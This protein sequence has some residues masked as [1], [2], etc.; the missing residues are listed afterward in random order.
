M[1]TTY[2]HDIFGKEVYKR[3]PREIKAVV[4]EEKR[5]YLIGLHGPDILFYYHPFF[6]NK[7]SKTGYDLHEK[8][9][10][11]FFCRNIVR[12]QEE[13]S[14]GL[15]AY[16][17]GFTCHFILDS[18]CHPYVSEY[19]KKNGV[20]HA[21]IETELDRYY[22]LR[23]GKDPLRYRPGVS[24]SPSL[25][26]NRIIAGTF[27]GISEKQIAAA[28]K[29]MKFYTDIMVCKTKRKREFLLGL[30]KLAGC[31]DSM[32]GQFMREEPDARC[33]ISTDILRH[34]YEDALDEAVEAIKNVYRCMTEEERLSNRFNRNFE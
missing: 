13:P 18:C 30:L 3:L 6:K 31:Y 24:I 33:E 9:A 22:M 5:L 27:L 1:P 23:E 16:L 11:E 19:E 32:E 12:Y 14:K 15:M 29:G 20:S 2:T 34:L 28:L 7:V 26:S 21:G 10:S 25:K 4:R 8:E 17:I